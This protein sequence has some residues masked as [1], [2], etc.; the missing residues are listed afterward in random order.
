MVGSVGWHTAAVWS[1]RWALRRNQVG[2]NLQRPSQRC[3]GT[4]LGESKGVVSLA[5][6]L[7]ARP[8]HRGDLSGLRGW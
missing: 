2:R 4:A 5:R 7:L 6:V 1:T 8:Q 3:T